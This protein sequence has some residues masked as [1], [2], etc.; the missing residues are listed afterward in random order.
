[1]H[2]AVPLNFGKKFMVSGN[3]LFVEHVFLDEL[4]SRYWGFLILFLFFPVSICLLSI[5]H[6]PRGGGRGAYKF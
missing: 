1:M 3:H 6:I 5:T 2:N 4:E